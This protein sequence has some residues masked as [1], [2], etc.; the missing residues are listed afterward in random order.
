MHDTVAD[1]AVMFMFRHFC[2]PAG[3]VRLLPCS[4]NAAAEDRQGKFPVIVFSHG[5]AVFCIYLQQLAQLHYA[6]LLHCQ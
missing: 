6:L 5:C 4:Y 2:L 1:D 3:S